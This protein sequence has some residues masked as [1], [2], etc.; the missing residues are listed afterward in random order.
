MP[1]APAVCANFEGGYC[2]VGIDHLDGEPVCRDSFFVM[3]FKRGGDGTSNIFPCDIDDALGRIGQ[4]G[5]SCREE[6]EMVYSASGT[7]VDDLDIC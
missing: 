3:N 4:C 5:E 2:F 1:S 7:F 6:V